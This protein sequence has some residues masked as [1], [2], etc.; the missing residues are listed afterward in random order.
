[1]LIAKAGM[2]RRVHRGFAGI[3]CAVS[4]PT[5]RQNKLSRPSSLKI[6]R[7]RYIAGVKYPYRVAS[8][9]SALGAETD[10]ETGLLDRKPEGFTVREQGSL[11]MF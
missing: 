4:G 5:R 9:A 2:M 8:K 10:T 1:V 7:F 6:G 11:T 3:H